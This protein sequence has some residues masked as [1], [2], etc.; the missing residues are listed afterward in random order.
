ME[1]RG[2]VGAAVVFLPRGVRSAEGLDL[3]GLVAPCDHVLGDLV[4][5]GKVA[6]RLAARLHA[7]SLQ[8]ATF[9][10]QQLRHKQSF[11]NRMIYIQKQCV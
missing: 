3:L 4:V 10:F 7:P 6:G 8:S 9:G 5:S 2:L 1:R 11:R